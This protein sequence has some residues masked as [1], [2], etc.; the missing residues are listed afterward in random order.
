MHVS[1]C[2][3]LEI[4]K[5]LISNVGFIDAETPDTCTWQY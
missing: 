3:L 1:I 4:L 5:T 2:V